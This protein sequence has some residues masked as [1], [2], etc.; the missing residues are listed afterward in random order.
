MGILILSLILNLSLIPAY[1]IIERGVMMRSEYSLSSSVMYIYDVGHVYTG[2]LAVMLCICFSTLCSGKILQHYIS[3]QQLTILKN[4]WKY[5]VWYVFDRLWFITG[6]MSAGTF[7]GTIWL[8][9][10]YELFGAEV[11]CQTFFEDTFIRVP[12]LISVGNRFVVEEDATLETVQFLT[13]GSIHFDSI[14]LESDVVFG[15]NSFVVLG[16]S[17]GQSFMLKPIS[18]VLECTKIPRDTVLTGVSHQTENNE[19]TLNSD[20]SS[21]PSS[22]GVNIWWHV[23]APLV[24]TIPQISSLEYYMSVIL[25]ILFVSQ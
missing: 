19:N 5:T 13:N 21:L 7:G 16:Y 22:F 8:S 24:I 25:G 20:S 17:I 14:T 6:T 11:G 15:T 18:T 23:F 3:K 1:F 4:S 2:L 10:I 9:K 12:F